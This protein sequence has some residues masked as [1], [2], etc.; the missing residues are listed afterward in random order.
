MQL[1]LV[2]FLADDKKTVSCTFEDLILCGYVTS[3]L[4]RWRW[5]RTSVKDSNPLTGPDVD[6]HNSAIG[7]LATNITD[8]FV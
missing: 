5:A 8:R 4:G 6:P 2:L 7:Q 1:S 3:Q